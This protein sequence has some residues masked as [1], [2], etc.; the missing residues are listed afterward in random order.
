MS[1]RAV[2]FVK[3]THTAD[4]PTSMWWVQSDTKKHKLEQT[5]NFRSLLTLYKWRLLKVS[6]SLQ[7]VKI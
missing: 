5:T 7:L 6:A 2:V 1:L 4:D 3:Q